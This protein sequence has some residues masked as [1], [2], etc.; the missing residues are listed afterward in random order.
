LF[1]IYFTNKLNL[2]M[3]RRRRNLKRA[4]ALGCAFLLVGLSAGFAQQSVTASGGDA[5]G[6][7]GSVSYS[8]GQVVYTQNSGANGS[9]VQGVQQPF[10][11]SVVSGLT[12]ASIQLNLST[13][14]NPTTE[15]LVLVA[16][17]LDQT[18]LSF[19]L[20]DI[21]GKLIESRAIVASETTISMRGLASATYLLKV[22][23][24]K[25]ELKTFR[26]IKY[27]D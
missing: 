18:Q 17:G 26:V 22:V 23:Q 3:K 27:K 13:Y 20:Y 7:G 25:E 15:N 14:P 4:K 8:V 12:N 11:I 2:V 19:N 21:S 5:S 10:E 16:D 1:Y 24:N 9:V 6:S